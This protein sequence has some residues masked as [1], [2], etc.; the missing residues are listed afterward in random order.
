MQSTSTHIHVEEIQ[1]QT[2]ESTVHARKKV[3]VIDDE[4]AVRKTLSLR[5]ERLGFQV[6][7]APDG[8]EGLEKSKQSIPDLIILDLLL[9][10][11]SGEEVCKAIR[12]D[13]NDEIAAIPII[14]LTGK[15]TIVDRVVG[16]VIGANA[17]ITKPFEFEQ[18]LK[19]IRSQ[20]LLD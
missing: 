12:E 13:D 2:A 17:Y 6:S 15:D 14:M 16:R 4:E 5:L 9:P 7:S 11:L 10:R 8:L 18:L 3:L 20:G 19:E 1:E